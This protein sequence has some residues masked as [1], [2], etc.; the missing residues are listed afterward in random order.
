MKTN[1]EKNPKLSKNSPLV[2]IIMGS[3]SDAEQMAPAK[4]ILEKFDV[5]YEFKVVSAHRAPEYM[6]EY[7]QQASARGLEIIIAA[8]GGAAGLPGMVASLT[9]LPVIGVPIKSKSL[10]GMD[11]LLSIVQM[12][13]GVPVAT[14]AIDGAA[15]AALLALRIL[16][17]K[18]PEVAEK[19]IQYREEL[20]EKVL[21]A[22]V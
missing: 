16:G 5:P 8:A 11:S 6:F 18:Y 3:A 7:V 21:K 13:A 9:T 15:N 19:L 20:K 1:P 4:E 22:K 17:I 14:V 10:N 2:G 12:P